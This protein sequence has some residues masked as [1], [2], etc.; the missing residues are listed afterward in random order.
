MSRPPWCDVPRCTARAQ[1]RAIP[2]H[3]VHSGQR[4]RPAPATSRTVSRPVAPGI[5][6]RWITIPKTAKIRE[7]SNIKALKFPIFP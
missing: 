5:K 7:G 3:R 2:R 1:H 4:T 6:T